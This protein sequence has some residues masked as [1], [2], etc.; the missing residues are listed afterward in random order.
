MMRIPNAPPTNTPKTKLM[1]LMFFSPQELESMIGLLPFF[2]V[3][4]NALT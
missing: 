3:Y 2:Q 4:G 1:I